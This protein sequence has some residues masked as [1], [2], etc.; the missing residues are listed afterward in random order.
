VVLHHEIYAANPGIGAVAT[1]QSPA[2][3]AFSVTGTPL[4]SNLIPESYVILREIP[5]VAYGRQFSDEE[6]LARELSPAMPVMLLENDAVL[7]TGAD[8]IQAFDRL[9][10]AEFSAR[11]ILNSQRLGSI[12]AIDATDLAAIA[13]KFGLV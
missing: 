9:E 2:V 1:A 6:H 5:L 8:L 13:E 10:V 3:T 7:T 12:Q 4:L 11:A